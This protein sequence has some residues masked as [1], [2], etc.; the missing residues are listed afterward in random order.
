MKRRTEKSNSFLSFIK[1]H[2]K[3]MIS[4]VVVVTFLGL[5]LTINYGRYVKDIIEVY[6]LRTKNFYFNSDKL[7]IHGTQY[8]IEPWEGVNPYTIHIQMDS[9]LNSLKGTTSDVDYDVECSTEGKIICSFDTE[10]SGI[11]SMSRKILT[12][13][14]KDGFNVYVKPS[15]TLS[16]GER[17]TVNITAKSTYPYEEELSATFVLIV[18]NYGVSYV[19]EDTS[20][21]IYFDYVVTNTLPDKKAKINLKIKDISKLTFDMT[22]SIFGTTGIEQKTDENQNINEVTFIV[23]P[24]SSMMVRFYKKDSKENYSHFSYDGESEV[25]EFSSEEID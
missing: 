8:E 7:T 22:S 24:K 21:D 19:I 2:K 17:V 15:E 6:Y 3:I 20:G 5:F 9:L 10:N 1:S 25:I 14:H 16:E 13:D 18:G 12:T 4:L 23:E 11:V